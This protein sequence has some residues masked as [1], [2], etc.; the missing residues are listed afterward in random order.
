MNGGNLSFRTNIFWGN[1]ASLSRTEAAFLFPQRFL[2]VKDGF[3]QCDWTRHII[4][5]LLWWY[6]CDSH[7]AERKTKSKAANTLFR[8]RRKPLGITETRRK[9]IYAYPTR[10][11]RKSEAANWSTFKDFLLMTWGQSVERQITTGEIT[12]K[13][14]WPVAETKETAGK[15]SVQLTTSSAWQ[16]AGAQRRTSECERPEG[17]KGTMRDRI[18]RKH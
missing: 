18:F 5:I 11:A 12:Y 6:K 1:A 17:P 4:I 8:Y 3:F 14:E 13:S 9:Y 16:M 2:L 10:T 7:S 15:F